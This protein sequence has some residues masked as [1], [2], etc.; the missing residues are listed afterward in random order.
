VRWTLDHMTG[1]LLILAG[2]H[3]R[4]ADVPWQNEAHRR[5]QRS[6]AQKRAAAAYFLIARCQPPPGAASAILNAATK[7]AKSSLLKLT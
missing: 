4:Q 3:S 2:C 1:L 6:R 5:S 7:S